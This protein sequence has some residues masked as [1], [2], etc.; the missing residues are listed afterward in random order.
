M[1]LISIYFLSGFGFNTLY[2]VIIP[3]YTDPI[4]RQANS[5]LARHLLVR[6]DQASVTKYLTLRMLTKQTPLR[7]QRRTLSTIKFHLHVSYVPI[8]FIKN[9]I[10]DVLLSNLNKNWTTNFFPKPE[11]DSP[12]LMFSWLNLHIIVPPTHSTVLLN[13]K[14]SETVVFD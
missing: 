10:F 3:W 9:Y 5:S 11:S 2:Y 8:I 14:Q 4:R 6:P 1:I 12:C 13:L 7:A